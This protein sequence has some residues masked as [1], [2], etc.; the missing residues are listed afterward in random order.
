MPGEPG[1]PLGPLIAQPRSV[2]EGDA[3]KGYLKQ[4][5]EALAPRLLERIFNA[6]GTPNKFWM[7]FSKRKFLN[8]EFP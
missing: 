6:D 2:A 1:W 7:M 5:R 3:L 8:K 4:L